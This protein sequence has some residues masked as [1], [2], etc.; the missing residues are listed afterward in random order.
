[1]ATT[2]SQPSE[3]R[4][5]DRPTLRDF[6][7]E[8]TDNIVQM[9]ERGV[10]PWQKPWE[11]GASPIGIPFN[12]TLARRRSQHRRLDDRVFQ[13]D[14]ARRREHGQLDSNRSEERLVHDSA[15]LQ[16][17]RT[18]L[19]QGMAAERDRV[20]EVVQSCILPRPNQWLTL[21]TSD[22]PRLLLNTS[23][24][25]HTSRRGGTHEWHGQFQL[26]KRTPKGTYVEA[27]SHSFAS[28]RR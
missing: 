9:L 20:S 21:T 8:V 5:S 18:V 2:T 4:H 11:P 17:A 6:R 19:H 12:P 13:P 25:K 15:T 16:P 28:L 7:Q 14:Q 22:N 10:A 3:R 24:R 26:F 23:T 27:S 1:M